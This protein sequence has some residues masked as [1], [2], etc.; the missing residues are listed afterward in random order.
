MNKFPVSLLRQ[1][2][3]C[4][5]DGLSIRVTAQKLGISK[6]SVS[7]LSETALSH[8]GGANVAE[9]I[10]LPDMQLLETFYPST[11]KA[12]QELDW[13]E[14]H[15]KLARRNVTLKLLYDAYKSQ[16]VRRPYTYTSF[17]RHYSEWRQTNGLGVPNGNV[18]AI[19]GERMEIA[20][21]GDNLKWI[22]PNCEVQRA[23][24]FI[25]VLPYSN[26]TYA[27]AF[28]NEKQQSWI[29][30]IVHALEYFGGTPQVL[31]MDNAKALVK[32]SSWYEG[33]VQLTVRSLCNY[34]DIEPWA[35]QPRRPKQ[36]N[37]VE[38]GVGLAQRRIIAAMQLERTP[39][40]RDLDHLNEQVKAKLEAL[41]NAPFTAT[42]RSNSR[43][44][45]FED[46]EREFLGRLPLQ[47]FC[48]LDI[49]VL[50][51][52]RG[53][54]VRI[55]GDGHRYSTPP[56]YTGK[57]VSVT[58]TDEKIYIYDLDSWGKI[59][60]HK[61]YKNPQGNKTHLLPEHLTKIPTPTSRMDCRVCQGR[62]AGRL[63]RS[64]GAASKKGKTN[65][66]CGR[67]C[68]ALMRLFKLF[69][70]SIIYQALSTRLEYGNVTYQETRKRCEQLI[71]AKENNLEPNIG[72][73]Q[74]IAD[75]Y[76][77][78]AHANIRNN[79]R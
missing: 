13:V 39:M 65:F 32:H 25:A 37:R 45:M 51:V 9:L 19:P 73:D 55:S 14:V 53:H 34:Y 4:M 21:A 29:S 40:A 16:V 66:P 42:E 44:Q 22:D 69:P 68:N 8:G 79:Y 70:V 36:K 41:N 24:L 71:W 57:R 49:R 46:E 63:C 43:R 59:A 67:A 74:R 47:T 7:L 18:Q 6:S 64:S 31:V 12:Y 50:V 5:Q 20:F 76:L 30:G 23:R 35:C 2:L 26:L 27:E 72:N 61:R 11:T 56:E 48:P 54:C 77:S 60:E 1:L 33:E 10:Q 15:K 28:P 3:G 75:G 58:I 17:C 62:I 52:D 38:A 78:P